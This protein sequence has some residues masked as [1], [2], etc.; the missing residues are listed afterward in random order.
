MLGIKNSRAADGRNRSRRFPLTHK[1]IFLCFLVVPIA[2]ILNGYFLLKFGSSFGVAIFW[3]SQFFIFL[4]LYLGRQWINKFFFITILSPIIFFLSVAVVYGLFYHCLAADIFAFLKGP[5]L[6]G[7]V[8]GSLCLLGNVR[9]RVAAMLFFSSLWYCSALSIFASYFLDV[10]KQTY[11]KMDAVEGFYFAGNEL[12][13][14]FAV[15]AALMVF[16]KPRRTIG[17]CFYAFLSLCVLFMLGTRGGWIIMGVCL[18][19]FLGIKLLRKRAFMLAFASSIGVI[20]LFSLEH[21]IMLIGPYMLSWGRFSW[22]ITRHG[23]WAGI[24]SGRLERLLEGLELIVSSS[25]WSWLFGMG[26]GAFQMALGKLFGYELLFTE[27]DLVDLLGSYGLFGFLWYYG[28]FSLL[29]IRGFLERTNRNEYLM[30][31][32]TSIGLVIYSM[33]AGHVAFMATPSIVVGILFWLLKHEPKQK[34][35]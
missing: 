13:V 27:T 21:I 35:F 33:V 15:A 5:A 7:A 6:L 34:N 20:L 31:I 25:P 12:T 14:A 16:V 28:L 3:K 1:L 9:G 4:W 23:F 24:S 18:T 10:G 11:K 8:Y 29:I 19:F 22:N 17:R 32:A 30:L 26:K 2:D